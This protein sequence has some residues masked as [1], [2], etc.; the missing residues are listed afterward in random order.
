VAL[1]E[2]ALISSVL[3]IIGGSALRPRNAANIYKGVSDLL[4]MASVNQWVMRRDV[5]GEASIRY[6]KVL[7]G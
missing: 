1:V 5:P 3:K 7:T 2:L 6:G 4:F